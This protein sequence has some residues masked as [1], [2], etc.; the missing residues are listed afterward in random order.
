FANEDEVAGNIALVQRGDCEFGLKVL[1]A[2][3]AG[4]IG[5]IVH[6]C[7]PAEAACS[8]VNGEDLVSMG[9]GEVGHLVTIPSTF[10]QQSTGLLIMEHAP[11]V[12]GYVR[13]VPINRDSDLDA[14]V[15]VHEYGHG[16]SNRL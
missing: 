12:E 9:A 10:V 14:G 8:A 5:V 1:N 2:Q 13:L 11:G 4:A 16:I 3:D 15:I 7:N 6:N